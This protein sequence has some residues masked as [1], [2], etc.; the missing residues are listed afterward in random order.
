[1]LFAEF[2]YMPFDLCHVF[3]L[4]SRMRVIPCY[5]CSESLFWPAV[6]Y[7]IPQRP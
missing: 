1:M 6:F 4:P 2:V 3:A 7:I 5:F